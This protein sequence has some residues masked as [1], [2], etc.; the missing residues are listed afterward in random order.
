M[1]LNVFVKEENWSCSGHP[2]VE[3]ST[4]HENEQG[5][6]WH[7]NS[8]LT[9]PN[10]FRIHRS[11][12]LWIVLSENINQGSPSSKQTCVSLCTFADLEH[13]NPNSISQDQHLYKLPSVVIRQRMDYFL[14]FVMRISFSKRLPMVWFN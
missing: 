13:W 5:F 3:T 8:L 1:H 9:Y 11:L 10:I 14:I 12:Y 7:R 6:E 2:F 4:L